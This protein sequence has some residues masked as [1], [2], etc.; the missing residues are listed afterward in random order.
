MDGKSLD[1]RK[2]KLE[3][4][5]QII[6]EA[7]AENKI[8]WEKLKATLG[9]DIEF[10]NERYVLNW[11]G[12]ADAFRVLQTPTTSTL[13]P[14]PEE[15]IDFETTKNIFIEGENLEVLKVLQKSYFGKIKMIY[16]DPPYNTGNDS[17]IYPDRFAESREEYLSRVGDKDES[18]YMTRE[19][20][21]R[22]NSKDSGHYHSN[23]LSMMYP[24][25]FL[26]RNLLRDDGLIFVSI[27]DNEIENLRLLMNEIF[28]ED[29]FVGQIIWKNKY[30]AGAKTKG[31][32]EV[33]EYIVCYSKNDIIDIESELSNEQILEYDKN[34]DEKYELRGGYVTQPLMTTSL[35]KRENLQYSIEHK[36]ETI[37]PR[38]QWV[39]EKERLIQAINNNEIV[40]KKK[41][42][43]TFSVRAKVYLKDEN[44]K[45]RNGKPL[46]ILN[47]PFNQAGTKEVA[48]LIG[49]DIYSFPKPSDLIKYLFSF[50]VNNKG[51]RSALYLDFFSGSGTSAQAIMD[52]NVKDGGTRNY[53][54]VQMP[55]LCDQNS[56]AFKAGY[57]TIAEICKERIR[58]V[59]KKIKDEQSEKLDLDNNFKHQDLGFKVFKLQKSNLKIWRPDLIENEDQLTNQLQIHTDALDEKAKTE[60]ILHELILKSGVDLTAGIELKHGYYMVNG[61]IILALEKMDEVLVKDIID[62]EPKKVIVL[63]RLFKENDQLKTN[64]ALQM[65]DA[66]IDFQVI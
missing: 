56:E 26:A 33:H 63:E 48:E 44:G 50:T 62:K 46:T 12:K 22:K 51:E 61:E 27:D 14:C 21:F 15:S 40:I 23:W 16:I 54:C 5:K 37:K 24:R 60:D 65:K 35:D 29:K 9:E 10:K 17:F 53:I 25:L 47:G 58:K 66:D 57:K 30:G 7:F 13:A 20:L 42:D 18:G 19:G 34:K 55:E 3:A 49:N 36:G 43:G 11:A 59:I 4:I 32:I 52:L 64:T 28:G 45:I 8:D 31:F 2:E 39:W 1:I 6:P 38:K 41:K